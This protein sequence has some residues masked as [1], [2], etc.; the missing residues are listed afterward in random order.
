MIMQQ[1][2]VDLAYSPYFFLLDVV[3]IDFNAFLFVCLFVM[4]VTMSFFV[5]KSVGKLVNFKPVRQIKE[6]NVSTFSFY[7]LA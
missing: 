2:F 1:I 7:L 5:I 3:Y 4:S 6:K